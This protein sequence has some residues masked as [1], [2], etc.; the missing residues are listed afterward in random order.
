VTGTIAL[1]DGATDTL[2]ISI[3]TTGTGIS[4]AILTGVDVITLASGVDATMTILQNA[5]ITTATATNIVTLSDI[6]A[7]TG[8]AAVES[9]VLANGTNTFTM[10]AN[11]QNIAAQGGSLLINAV[12]FELGTITETA[13]TNIT[14]DMT[15]GVAGTLINLDGA[16]LAKIDT[17][18]LRGD[19]AHNVI[20]WASINWDGI[21]ASNITTFAGGLDIRASTGDQALT[22]SAGN[23]VIATGLGDDTVN[24]GAI[25]DGGNDT[26]VYSG[27]NANDVNITG[28][29]TGVG[30]DYDVLDFANLT[31]TRGTTAD[32]V[33]F[34]SFISGSV[35]ANATVIAFNN[36]QLDS[37]ENVATTVQAI[38]GGLGKSS[39]MIFLIA[40]S[41]NDKIGV[42]S[43]EDSNIAD[44]AGKV[45]ASELVML[46]ELLGYTNSAITAL[47]A[48]DASNFSHTYIA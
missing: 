24:L 1:G 34:Q 37:A 23:D 43:W 32:D 46:G 30:T 2:N 39:K 9:Y 5:M 7:A 35:E 3:D 36:L 21:G 44:P 40:D 18:V 47:A 11:D 17:L 31:L 45:D 48:M 22:G 26:V 28:F 38:T 10:G 4:T 13:A 15:N 27:R 29:T 33:N 12:N 25:D 14:L 42:W 8:K 6:G 20:D 19:Q 16:S 41:G